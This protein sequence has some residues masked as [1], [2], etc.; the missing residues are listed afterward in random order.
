MVAG[1]VFL[2]LLLLPAVF[3]KPW[4]VLYEVTGLAAEGEMLPLFHYEGNTAEESTDNFYA[5]YSIP[6]IDQQIFRDRLVELVREKETIQKEIIA[7]ATRLE[8]QAQLAMHIP[9]E[10]EVDGVIRSSVLVHEPRGDMEQEARTFCSLNGQLGHEHSMMSNCIST[11]QHIIWEHYIGSLSEWLHASALRY[12][13]CETGFADGDMVLPSLVPAFRK[14]QAVDKHLVV[15]DVGAALGSFSTKV[16]AIFGDVATARMMRIAKNAGVRDMMLEL[17]NWNPTQQWTLI[18]VEPNT[19]SLPILK[20]VLAIPEE[21]S[22]YMSMRTVIVEGAAGTSQGTTT[23]YHTGKVGEQDHVPLYQNEQTTHKLEVNINTVDEIFKENTADLPPSVTSELFLLKVDTE[24]HD[25]KVIKGAQ[26]L[27][28]ARAIHFIVFEYHIKWPQE[29]TLRDTVEYLASFGYICAFLRSRNII[30]IS[31]KWWLNAY[32]EPALQIW[33]NVLCARDEKELSRICA[34][35][36]QDFD[37]HT[38]MA[39]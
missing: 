27:L 36:N 22:E 31:E 20:D 2:F 28:Q 21:F 37:V 16:Q 25:V 1:T 34:G 6:E 39:W 5:K 23:F 9:L 32:G 3:C 18:A 24:G 38:Y 30:P 4:Y 15:M 17:M 29:D 10:I 12:A 35:H 7:N 8:S 26:E 13:G 14:A 33:S 11:V 19:L